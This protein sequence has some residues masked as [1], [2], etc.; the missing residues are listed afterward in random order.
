MYSQ[1][2]MHGQKNIKLSTSTFKAYRPSAGTYLWH[3]RPCHLLRY[4]GQ[5]PVELMCHRMTYQ[6]NRGSIA[7]G[8]KRVIS[9]PKRADRPWGWHSFSAEVKNKG[10]STTI[11]ENTFMSCT[12]KTLRLAWRG[13]W[14]FV[15]GHKKT[16]QNL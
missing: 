5:W 16:S 1:L 3:R 11:P 9:S 7:G 15:P 4:C 13:H 12:T 10:S 8:D 2:M 6:R 14:C